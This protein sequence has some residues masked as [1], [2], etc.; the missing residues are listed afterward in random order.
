MILSAKAN[1]RKCKNAGNHFKKLP[2]F[3]LIGG[4]LK[5]ERSINK[6]A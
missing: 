1:T 3:L 5:H 4:L 2:A 6:M